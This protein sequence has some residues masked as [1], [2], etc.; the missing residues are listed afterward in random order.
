VNPECTVDI[1]NR[2]LARD[3]D[4]D[5]RRVGAEAIDVLALSES[6]VLTMV[7][8]VAPI[9]AGDQIVF[10]LGNYRGDV[11]MLNLQTSD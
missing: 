7:S 5:E 8:S 11:F 4:P 2:V 9:I 1:R 6:I 3:F 10:V